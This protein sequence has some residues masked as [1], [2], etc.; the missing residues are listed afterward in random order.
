VL[1]LLFVIVIEEPITSTITSISTM[2]A[3]LPPGTASSTAQDR[4]A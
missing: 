2:S 1:V 4:P 3:N